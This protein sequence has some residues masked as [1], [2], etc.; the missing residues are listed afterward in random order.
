MLTVSRAG[1][2]PKRL[3]KRGLE[4]AR[5]SRSTQSAFHEQSLVRIVNVYLEENA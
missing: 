4:L 2:R 5:R 1:C 3:G